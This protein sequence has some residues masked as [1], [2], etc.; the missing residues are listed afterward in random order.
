ML[1]YYKTPRWSDIKNET[2][3]SSTV[4][5]P[6]NSFL[7]G[8]N[9]PLQTAYYFCDALD[10]NYHSHLSSKREENPTVKLDFAS[11]PVWENDGSKKIFLQIVCDDG[12]TIESSSVGFN[13]TTTIASSSDVQIYNY[14]SSGELLIS[15]FLFL[16]ILLHMIAL[17]ANSFVNT[18]VKRK[19]LAYG[20]GDVE[21]TD[22]S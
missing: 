10:Q 3:L 1:I 4:T 2:N 21:I 11:M 14:M 8:E 22:R 18:T 7:S 13:P 20:G 19:Y 6:D 9:N 15:L 12:I 5:V 16:T 17:L